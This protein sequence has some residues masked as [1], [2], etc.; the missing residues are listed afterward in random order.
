[1]Q[2]TLARERRALDATLARQLAEERARAED[3][4]RASREATE[5]AEARARAAD[6]EA[7]RLRARLEALAGG[8]DCGPGAGVDGGA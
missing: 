6:A 7:A 5:A 8:G 4:V 2:E 3:A 1:V